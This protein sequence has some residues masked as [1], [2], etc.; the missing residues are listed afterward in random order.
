MLIRPQGHTIEI[1]KYAIAVRP[2]QRHARA[3]LNKFTLQRHAGTTNFGKARRV[4]NGTA[5]AALRKL[6]NDFDTGGVGYGN[7]ARVWRCGQ[8]G[9]IRVAAQAFDEGVARMYRPE[10]PR[11]AE[12]A[13]LP[14][15]F[16]CRLAA[17]HG[18]VARREQSLQRRT[19]QGSVHKAQAP[20]SRSMAREMM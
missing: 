15:Y 19:Q 6:A 20:N 14:Q 7:K 16:S 2:D 18:N 9:N 1:I 10:F 3:S 17:E 8:A 4:A 5:S 13:A 11:K 12:L